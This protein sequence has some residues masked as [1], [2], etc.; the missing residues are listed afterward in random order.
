MQG[1]LRTRRGKLL[2]VLVGAVFVSLFSVGCVQ[3]I[4]RS[5][6][7]SRR[8]VRSGDADG[9]PVFLEFPKSGRTWMRCMIGAVVAQQQG[10]S[11]EQDIDD[12]DALSKQFTFTHGDQVWHQHPYHA[13]PDELPSVEQMLTE[14]RSRR[15]VILVR[16]PRDVIVSSFY[17]RSRRGKEWSYAYSGS[18]AA[19]LREERGGWL[20]LL[21]FMRRLRA[22]QASHSSSVLLLRYEDTAACAA[23]TLRRL[24]RFLDMDSGVGI[25]QFNASAAAESAGRLHC[26]LAP[27]PGVALSLRACMPCCAAA[28]CSF[29]RMQR[30]ADNAASARLRPADAADPQ[31]RKVR[32][33]AVGG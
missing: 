26:K 5:L 10:K 24:L 12:L 3:C 19:F 7:G 31:S 27:V 25:S 28:R 15:L 13:N 1:V 22:L 29:S 23:C 6:L 33:G 16:D 9:K 11:V 18:M 4:L 8:K 2:A 32:S 17:E 14:F 30:E 20:T 21:E